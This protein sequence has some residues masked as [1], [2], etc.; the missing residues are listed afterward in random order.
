VL[1]DLDKAAEDL[2][3]AIARLA[4]A[5]TKEREA[6]ESEHPVQNRLWRGFI[7]GL[8]EYSEAWTTA[9]RL[10]Q[11]GATLRDAISPIIQPAQMLSAIG[12][13]LGLGLQRSENRS[14]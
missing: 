6:S 2:R 5:L 11:H 8:V 14:A 10:R 9:T 1:N 4:T 3:S 12:S 7:A 13:H